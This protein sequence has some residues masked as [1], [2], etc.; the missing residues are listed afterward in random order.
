MR[1]QGVAN[2]PAEAKQLEEEPEGGGGEERREGIARPLLR[3]E[4]RHAEGA[5]RRPR[6]RDEVLSTRTHIHTQKEKERE[7]EKRTRAHTERKV[8][9]RA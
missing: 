9:K 6:R 1:P 8:L 5:I 4:R 2:V 7:K 3:E